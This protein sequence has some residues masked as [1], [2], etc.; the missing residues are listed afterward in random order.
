VRFWKLWAPAL[1]MTLVS[2]ISYIDRNTLAI[3]APTILEENHLSAEQY[4]WIISA[5]SI[6]YLIGNP[7]WGR[8]LD[9]YGVRYGMLAAV[10]FWTVSSAS[11]AWVGSFAG[12]ALARAALGFGEGATFPG[13]L[14]TALTTLP[15]RWRARGVALAYSGGSL[16]AVVA[17]LIVQ[18]VANAYTWR[19]AF[20][21][22]GLIGALWLAQWLVIGPLVPHVPRHT[23][24]AAMDWRDRRLWS[25]I[26]S[27]A[28]GCLPL[29]FIIYSGPI[30][31][32]RVWHKPQADISAVLWIPPLGWEIGYFLGGYILDRYSHPFRRMTWFWLFG[33]L[34]LAVIPLLGSYWMVLAVLFWTMFVSGANIITTVSYAPE[35]FGA[36]QAG[37]IAGIGAGSWSLAVAVSMPGFGALIDR[38]AWMGAFALATACA[39]TGYSLWLGLAGNRR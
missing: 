12:F 34:P 3:L 25:Y 18:P 6:A 13:G 5:F 22:T 37:L 33:I 8:V 39:V 16:G 21:F 1:A 35:T 29:G 11:H 23:A 19:G 4:G 20:I 30:F 27:Y 14:R 17:P 15:E 26:A 10:A 28:L 24:P 36:E 38:A 7:V 32:S 2:L 31:L 9:R